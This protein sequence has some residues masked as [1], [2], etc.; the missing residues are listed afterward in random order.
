VDDRE[1]AIGIRRYTAMS[2]EFP[3]STS[4]FPQ[5]GGSEV[6]DVPLRS[7]NPHASGPA[8][9]ATL[10]IAE[11]LKNSPI[12]IED[13]PKNLALYQRR[14]VIADILSIN[15]I[16]KKIK[17]VP[18]VLMEFGTLWGRRLALLI[19][20]REIY[21]PYDY[22][23]QVIGFDTFAGFPDVHHNDGSHTEIRSGSMSVTP[24]YEQHLTQ[25]LNIHEM[26]SYH[27]HFR[28]FELK[29]GD[30]RQTLP[31]YLTSH[32]EAIVSLA[33][34]D[35]DLYEPTRACLELLRPRLIRGSILAF[36]EL[37]HPAYPGETIA[38][39]ESLDLKPS[40]VEKLPY[41]RSP[42]MITV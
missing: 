6:S 17:H 35:M 28:R 27:A 8:L 40:A 38:L 9:Y 24:G 16:Y 31:E 33:Y 34:F 26:E 21:E 30:V 29:R 19:A 18:G 36:D 10:K 3:K 11:L 22:T 15:D 32:P 20:L 7:S 37:V 42:T 41:G 39:L 5:L 25:V 12:P 1:A 13:L 14:D 2:N 23:R 4:Q